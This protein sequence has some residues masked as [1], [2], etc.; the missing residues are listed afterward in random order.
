MREAV[1]QTNLSH[2]DKLNVTGLFAFE[3]ILFAIPDQ[4]QYS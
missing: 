2:F 4:E 1:S 3:T